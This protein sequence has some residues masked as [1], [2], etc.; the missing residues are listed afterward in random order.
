M[1]K[2][3]EFCHRLDLV[4]R[5]S[6]ATTGRPVRGQRAVFRR[7]NTKIPLVYK[8]TGIYAMIDSMRGEF[9]LTVS[10]PGYFTRTVPVSCENGRELPMTELPLIPQD[11]DPVYGGFRTWEGIKNGIQIVEG[12]EY[13]NWELRVKEADRENSMLILHNPHRIMLSEE[14]YGLIDTEKGTYEPFVTS[15]QNNGDEIRIK[16]TGKNSFLSKAVN[17]GSPVGRIISGMVWEDGRFIWRARSRLETDRF[18]M[19]TIT[20]GREQFQTMEFCEKGGM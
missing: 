14:R 13:G 12:V 17:P 6:D 16:G 11:D 8:D 1:D 15:S 10:V 3:D 7:G 18:L 4:I 5:L 2:M 20:A 9:L 19:R